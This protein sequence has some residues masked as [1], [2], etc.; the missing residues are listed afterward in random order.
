METEMILW[1]ALYHVHESKMLK[2]ARI[3]IEA[4]C[5]KD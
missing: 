3:A 2:E 1:A 5:S 4:M